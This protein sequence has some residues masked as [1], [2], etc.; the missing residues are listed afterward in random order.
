MFE[1][2]DH[3]GI[4][5]TLGRQTRRE[6]LTAKNNVHEKCSGSFED[7]LSFMYNISLNFCDWRVISVY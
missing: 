4:P 1:T 5:Y 6:R 7:D 3:L 2:C